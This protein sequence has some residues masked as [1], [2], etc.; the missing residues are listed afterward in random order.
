MP[1]HTIAENL[2]RL[3]T[4]RTN[5]A[6]AITGKGG[7]VASGA[8][9]EDFP[10]AIGT[11]PAGGGG[12]SQD[13]IDLIEGDIT[14][15]SIPSGVTKVGWYAFAEC[16]ALTSVT[17]PNTVTRIEGY[18]FRHCPQLAEVTFPTSSLLYIGENA[19]EG[20]SAVPY[21]LRSVTLPSS[22]NAIGNRLFQLNRGLKYLDL[23]ATNITST[24]EYL[25]SE[26]SL[27]QTLKLPTGLTTIG[28]N[29]CYNCTSLTSV[30]IPSSVTSI[31]INAF[32]QCSALTAIVIPENVAT[33]AA[34]AFNG[35][36]QL[37]SIKFESTTPPTVSNANAWTNIPTTCTIQVPTGSLT[38]YTTANNY[39]NPNTYTYV[40]Y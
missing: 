38:A 17:I 29:M 34:Y 6:T 37:T 16:V 15:I 32:Q 30:T 9:L 28:R 39:P 2:T 12:G 23:S 35:C 7:T 33:I 14:S 1:D 22:V 5:I 10:T 4:A 27:L 18:A 13:L 3:Q 11:I 25:A 19:F 40:E 26:C 24:G 8:G 20:T 36:T 31:G 21:S